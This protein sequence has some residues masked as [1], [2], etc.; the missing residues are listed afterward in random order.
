MNTSILSMNYNILYNKE[1]T[2][3]INIINQKIIFKKKEPYVFQY[4]NIL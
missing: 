2:I 4:K 3:Y 1:N